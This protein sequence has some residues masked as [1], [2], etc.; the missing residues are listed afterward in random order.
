[1]AAPGRILTFP[2]FRDSRGDL[3]VFEPPTVP[4]DVRRVYILRGA[5]EGSSRGGHAHREL[6]QLIVAAEGAFTVWLENGDS[7]SIFRLSSPS[8]GLLIEAM[9]WR[10][11]REFTPGAVAVVLAS[12]IYDEADYI[13]DHETYLRQVRGDI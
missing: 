4:F 7:S 9:T 11:L 2:D 8:Q 1:M 5:P 3:I 13:R 12:E 6:R 10:E